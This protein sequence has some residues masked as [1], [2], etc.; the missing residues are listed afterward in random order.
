[1]TPSP[2]W[3]CGCTPKT[4]ESTCSR[5]GMRPRVAPTQRQAYRKLAG[6][7]LGA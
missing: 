4:H 5:C 2:C 6:W 7:I 1:M 3:F